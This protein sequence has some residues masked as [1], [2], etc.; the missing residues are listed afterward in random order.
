MKID[1]VGLIALGFTISF[2]FYVYT[3]YIPN[4]GISV[5]GLNDIAAKSLMSW[6]AIFS[7]ISVFVTTILVTKIKPIYLVILY[8]LISLVFLIL[9]IAF[10]SVMLARITSAVVGFFAAG[11]VW[12][13]GLAVLTQYFPQKKGKSDWL[14]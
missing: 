12:Q 10:P 1:G 7:L 14:L 3:Q 11:G 13:L 8:P 2:T 4:F 9:M 5:L 6:Y